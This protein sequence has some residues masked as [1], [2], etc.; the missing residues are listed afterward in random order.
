MKINKFKFSSCWKKILFK[1]NKSFKSIN[2][3]TTYLKER[4]NHFSTDQLK[5]TKYSNTKVVRRSNLFIPK[6]FEAPLDASTL[7]HQLMLRSG[8]M[9]KS[10]VGIYSLLPLGVRSLEKLTKLVD[11]IMKEN[12]EKKKKKNFTLK[13]KKKKLF[14]L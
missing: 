3:N 11:K 14:K 13:R 12:G 7:S 10:S 8:M 5:E 9:R 4:K 6:L 1:Q 2:H